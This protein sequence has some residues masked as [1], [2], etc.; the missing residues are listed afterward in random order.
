MSDLTVFVCGT[1]P[2]HE[3]DSDGPAMCGGENPDGSYWRGLES[4]PENR[5]RANWGSVTCSKCGVTAM[6]KDM[7]SGGW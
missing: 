3:C 4:D 7:A 1:K 5:R 2:V 6:D